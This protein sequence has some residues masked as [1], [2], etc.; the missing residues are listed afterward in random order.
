[1]QVEPVTPLDEMLGQYEDAHP[2]ETEVDQVEWKAFWAKFQRYRTLCIPCIAQ[3]N[4]KQRH[5]AMGGIADE[6]IKDL[7]TEW[8]P[9]YLTAASR[10]ILIA[11]HRKARERIFGRGG[12]RRRFLRPRT[13][14][15][16]IRCHD[17]EALP[18]LLL[19]LGVSR[20][21]LVYVCVPCVCV[22]LVCPT[23]GRR[24]PMRAAADF[25]DD[26]DSDVE[27]ADW[28]AK[29]VYVSEATRAIAIKWLRTARGR[30]Q[31]G[32]AATT[33]TNAVARTARTAT[34]TP[35]GKAPKSRGESKM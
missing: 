3:R 11:W 8:G 29:P 9:V 33:P 12:E 1:V 6:D 22:F 18:L 32:G 16:C 19:F 14:R 31:A 15:G 2:G 7:N 13:R 27:K 30:I 34:R 23:T 24:R 21:V 26:E 28:A 25:S 5:V 17:V 10:A 35:G 20:V 4:Q